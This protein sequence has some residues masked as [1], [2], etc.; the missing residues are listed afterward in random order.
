MAILPS[1]VFLLYSTI[2]KTVSN[3]SHF[4]QAVAVKNKIRPYILVFADNYT[5]YAGSFY[6]NS[7]LIGNWSDF[8]A[9]EKDFTL[10][11]IS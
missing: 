11:Y 7:I 10:L 1:A 4:R 6:S 3:S 2:I 5:L 9:K 8:E